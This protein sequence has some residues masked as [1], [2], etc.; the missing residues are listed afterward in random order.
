MR[1]QLWRSLIRKPTIIPSKSRAVTASAIR[2]LSTT[3]SSPLNSEN[4]LRIGRRGS[5]IPNNN[6]YAGRWFTDD[7]AAE[8]DDVMNQ[9]RESMAFDVLIVGGGPAGLAA[10]IRMKQLCIEKEK[11]L[12]VCVI[13]KGRYVEKP[14]LQ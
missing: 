9:P 7:A 4:P 14:A 3:I 11:D 12:S 10:A 8:E 13:D 2:S 1:S 6:H 5:S